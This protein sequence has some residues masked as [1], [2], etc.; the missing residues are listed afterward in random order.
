[1]GRFFADPLGFVMFAYP[2]ETDPELQIVELP[3]PWASRFPTCFFGPDA[4]ACEF[5]ENVSANV[6]A[7]GFVPGGSAVA[8]IR[9][10]VASGHGI[11]KS[12]LVAWLV[13][14]IMSTR[15]FCQGTITANTAAQL[16]TKTWAQIAKWTKKCITGH[17]FTITTGRGSMAMR[18][19][20]HPE[21]WF[22][23]AQTCDEENSEAFAGQHS[24]S[25]TSFYINDEASAIPPKIWEVQNGGLTD[26]EPMQFAFGNPT[27]SSGDFHTC[28]HKLRHRWG[29][30]QIDSRSVQITNKK[31]LQE[32]IDDYGID[33]DMVKIRVRGMFP[34]MSALQFISTKDVDAAIARYLAPSSYNFAP[35]ILTLDNAWEGDDEGVIGKRQ[36]LKYETLDYFAKNDNDIEVA[37]KL[38][39]LEEEHEADAVFIDAGYGTGV[40]SAGKTMGRDWELVWF[41]GES[42]D[43]GFLN[44]RAWIWGQS[45]NWLKNGGALDE[46]DLVLYSDLVNMHTVPRMDGVVQL[47]AK[48]DAKRREVPSPGRGDALALSF[49]RPVQKK[50]R[51]LKKYV[52]SLKPKN[53][54]HNPYETIEK[55]S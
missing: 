25:S 11:G 45:R 16:Q 48:K 5:L 22:C 8:A 13:D 19:R 12:A 28:F 37:N 36:G 33:S 31:F 43:P 34:A 32:L 3:E 47:E 54:D 26:G 15:P 14:W 6:R 53:R 38:A 41:A 44:M 7:N 40:Y 55:D 17:W 49:A 21:S 24:A 27:Q 39:R 30:R 2:W 52:G 10:A 51:G 23:T 20:A 18:H 4:W 50:V 1:M 29:T 35:V 9:E 46:R 42:P